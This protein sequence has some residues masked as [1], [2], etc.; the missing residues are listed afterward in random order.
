[1][2]RASSSKTKG[3]YWIY[4]KCLFYLW[5]YNEK[6]SDKKCSIRWFDLL[7]DCSQEIL[8]LAWDLNAQNLE[9]YLGFLNYS[10]KNWINIT[11]TINCRLSILSKHEWAINDSTPR[12]F[13]ISLNLLSSIQTFNRTFLPCRIWLHVNIHPTLPVIYE[14]HQLATSSLLKRLNRVLLKRFECRH[15]RYCF[16]NHDP[17]FLIDLIKRWHGPCFC[18]SLEIFL[19][20]MLP[21][22]SNQ[23]GWSML[24]IIRLCFVFVV[25]Y[26]RTI[27]TTIKHNTTYFVIGSDVIRILIKD[28]L[29]WAVW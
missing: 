20:C 16:L 29:V 8:N 1:M 25:L 27:F 14:E 17:V 12:F 21:S 23:Q 10:S 13:L 24:T 22:F 11:S 9:K 28:C 5:K 15:L 6:Q 18:H 19:D 26:V 7:L 3:F 4:W 2:Q